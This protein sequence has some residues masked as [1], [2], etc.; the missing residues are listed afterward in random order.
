MKNQTMDPILLAVDLG[1]SV[2]DVADGYVKAFNKLGGAYMII[3]FTTREPTSQEVLVSR[4][5][6]RRLG[7]VVEAVGDHFESV[8]GKVRK[9]I[10]VL[11]PGKVQ[12]TPDHIMKLRPKVEPIKIEVTPEG[13]KE[14]KND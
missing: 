8:L 2:D 1:Y 9:R 12:K 7:G 13:V 6:A 3:D 14:V 4:K 11:V 10:F 5:Y